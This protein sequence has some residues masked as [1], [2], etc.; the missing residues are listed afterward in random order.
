MFIIWDAMIY[1]CK[2]LCV[3]K[4]TNMR[5]LCISPLLLFI[6]SKMKFLFFTTIIS[7][8]DAADTWNVYF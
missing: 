8:N 4:L 2:F 3:A 5:I 7:G 6:V 1:F